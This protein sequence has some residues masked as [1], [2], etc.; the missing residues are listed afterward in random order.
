MS[1]RPEQ[2]DSDA[3]RRDVAKIDRTVLTASVAA[4]VVWAGLVWTHIFQL[5]V[6][7]D[8]LLDVDE[9]VSCNRLE[10]RFPQVDRVLRFGALLGLLVAATGCWIWPRRWKW[11][12]IA[13][14]FLLAMAGLV[15][16]G[17]DR[18]GVR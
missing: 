8:C 6:W 18:N 15:V 12:W 3:A 2:A 9:S 16:A 1:E 4:L 17:I 7:G 14:G 13:G 10:A 11:I 5:M